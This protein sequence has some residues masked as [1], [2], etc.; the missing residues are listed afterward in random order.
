MKF[1]YGLISLLG[2]LLCGVVDKIETPFIDFFDALNFIT[3]YNEKEKEFHNKT[4]I[5]IEE[6]KKDLEKFN[7]ENE[8]DVFK[9]NI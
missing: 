1:Y 7:F 4:K 6:E 2:M 5:V 9:R 3:F 8:N